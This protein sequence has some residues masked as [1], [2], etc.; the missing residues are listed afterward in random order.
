MFK[1]IMD[2]LGHSQFIVPACII[3][4]HCTNSG[5]DFWAFFK[6]VNLSNDWKTALVVLVFRKGSCVDY[7]DQFL[8]HAFNV[9]YLSIMFIHLY[10][11]I[12]QTVT[13]SANQKTTLLWNACSYLMKHH[14]GIFYQSHILTRFHTDTLSWKYPQL[15]LW[16]QFLTSR[17]IRGPNTEP[18]G[19]QAENFARRV[20][21]VC[22]FIYDVSTHNLHIIANRTTPVVVLHPNLPEETSYNRCLLFYEA[23]MPKWFFDIGLCRDPMMTILSSLS[24]CN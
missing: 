20:L 23:T 16:F 17:N 2:V 13:S 14:T 6:Q 9:N 21:L 4:T 18:W 11:L 3:K 8:S 7:I 5:N 22:P 10:L 1:S 12:L 19:M 15:D 24:Y